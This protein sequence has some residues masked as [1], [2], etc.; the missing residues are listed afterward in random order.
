MFEFSF[1]VPLFGAFFR[2]RPFGGF[3]LKNL[4]F[5]GFVLPNGKQAR[6]FAVLLQGLKDSSGAIAEI[7]VKRRFYKVHDDFLLAGDLD[8]SPFGLNQ[9]NG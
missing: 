6:V 8:S 5:G 4:S 7:G 1:F 2:I 3:Y 9:L